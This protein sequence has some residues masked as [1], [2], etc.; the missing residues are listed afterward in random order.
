MQLLGTDPVTPPA[1]SLQKNLNPVA[2]LKF[3][4]SQITGVRRLTTNVLGNPT[5]GQKAEAKTWLPLFV[6]DLIWSL[7]TVDT[8]IGPSNY[9]GA[10]RADASNNDAQ[11]DI[12]YEDLLAVVNKYKGPGFYA[13][14][15]S[16]M[17]ADDALAQA[18][19]AAFTQWNQA[20]S[21]RPIGSALVTSNEAKIMSGA[22]SDT[23]AAPRD[24]KKISILTTQEI[25]ERSAMTRK[26]APGVKP[27]ETLLQYATGG[28]GVKSGTGIFNPMEQAGD[29]PPPEKKPVNPLVWVGVAVAGYF[30]YKSMA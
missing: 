23:F 12:I 22:M 2:L 30:A 29:V 15:G 7:E 11:M 13:T 17:T 10:Y 3:T 18:A 19:N 21:G 1:K 26:I 28:S 5:V 4:A 16:N 14:T 27:G 8:L 24:I 9:R 6:N 20:K 25:A